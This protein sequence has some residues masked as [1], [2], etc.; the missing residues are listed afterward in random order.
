MRSFFTGSLIFSLLVFSGA[1]QAFDADACFN[2]Y[3]APLSFDTSKGGLPSLVTTPIGI[4]GARRLADGRFLAN[5]NTKT[6]IY[7]A[8]GSIEIGDTCGATS[9]T[10]NSQTLM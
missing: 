10:E 8:S 6:K 1:A 9:S 3:S 7:S 5:E 2:L 4:N